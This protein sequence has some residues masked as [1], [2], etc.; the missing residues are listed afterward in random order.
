MLQ[1]HRFRMLHLHWNMLHV[2]CGMQRVHCGM[3]R[4]YSGM[5]PAIFCAIFWVNSMFLG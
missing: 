2:H 3:Q 4:V 5:Q 1:L